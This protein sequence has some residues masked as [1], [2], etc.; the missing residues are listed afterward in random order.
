VPVFVVYR[1]RGSKLS[2]FL[3]VSC[4]RQMSPRRGADPTILRGN[5]K[6][7]PC[8]QLLFAILLIVVPRL[9]GTSPAR[10]PSLLGQ[11]YYSWFLLWSAFELSQSLVQ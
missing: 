1:S 9:Q 10:R 2:P 11:H 8:T 6:T 3:A 4:S 5:R 7:S